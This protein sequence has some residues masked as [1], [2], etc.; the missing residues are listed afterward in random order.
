M[1]RSGE[2][3]RGL[4]G[5]VS[6]RP[7]RGERTA[8]HVQNLVMRSYC[9]KIGA[10]YLLGAVEYIMPDCRLVLDRLLGALEE[11]D[12]L[13]FFSL[14]MLPRNRRDRRALCGRFLE[15]GRQLHFA[16]E[17]TCL[18]DERDLERLDDLFGVQELLDSTTHGLPGLREVR[19]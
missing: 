13:V 19:A 15:T 18:S 9:Q 12:G 7:I 10:R 2:L 1:S 17:E 3:A 8:Q 5:Y 4:R 6:S 16:L 11:V 14:W